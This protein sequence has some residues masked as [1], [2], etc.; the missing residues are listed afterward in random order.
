M[1]IGNIIGLAAGMFGLGAVWSVS[2]QAQVRTY[3]PETIRTVSSY[4]SGRRASRVRCVSASQRLCRVA[5]DNGGVVHEISLRQET[6]FTFRA[7]SRDARKCDRG[8]NPM[9]ACNWQRITPAGGI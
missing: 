8:R 5:V 2:L 9:M 4:D 1:R 3:P 6:S 7:I